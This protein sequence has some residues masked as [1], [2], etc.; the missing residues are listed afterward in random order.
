LCK[1]LPVFAACI[2]FYLAR[3]ANLLKGLYILPSVI[4]SFSSFFTMSKAIYWTDFHD[5]FTKGNVFT[6]IF[7]IRSSFSDPSRDVAM[8]NNL[9]AKWGK[10][11]TPCTYRLSFRNGMG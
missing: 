11:T 3:S 9:V 2:L 8:A 4:S 7:L 6:S 10:I 1:L 5:L